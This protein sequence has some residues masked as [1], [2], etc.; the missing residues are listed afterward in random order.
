MICHPGPAIGYQDVTS[1]PLE[2]VR[3][4]LEPVAGTKER[5]R[6]FQR[7]VASLHNRD[8]AA[9]EPALRQLTVPT[10]MVWGTGD[11]FFRLRHVEQLRD[12]IPGATGVVTVDGGRLF[13]PGERAAD[14]ITHLRA[15]WAV[16]HA[17]AGPA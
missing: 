6:E 4:Y 15:C 8:L 17:S 16:H 5:A 13:F 9:V 2:V 12:M 1:L 10:L 7:W 14:L 11:I 3:A